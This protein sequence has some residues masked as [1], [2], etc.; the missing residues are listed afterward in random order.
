MLIEEERY[1]F[2]RDEIHA[3]GYELAQVTR[4]IVRLE[5]AKKKTMKALREEIE[6]KY[7]EQLDIA[8]KIEDGYEMRPVAIAPL[9]PEKPMK[10]KNDGTLQ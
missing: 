10:K 6:D 8:Q 7:S 9:P 4:E 5:K 3:F 2:T 1:D